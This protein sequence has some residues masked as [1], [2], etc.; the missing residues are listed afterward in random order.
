MSKEI[1]EVRHSKKNM[2]SYG[3]GNFMNEFLAMA[4]G[5]W[6]FYFYE[7]ELGLNVVLV[8]LGFFIFAVYN[9]INDP[10]VGYLTNRPFKFTKKWGRRFPWILMGAVPFIFSYI[11]IFTP[12]AVNTESGAWILFL[13]LVFTTCIFDTFNSIFWVNFS[14]LFP[15]KFRSIKERR[16]A[17]GLQIPVGLVGIALGAI[18]PPIFVDFGVPS[19]YITQ[20]GVVIIVG[21]IAI[22]LAIPGV[23]DDQDA[24]DRYLETYDSREKSP[25]FFK[26]LGAALKQKSFI[27]FI[28]SYTLYRTLVQSMTSSVPYLVDNVLEMTEKATIPIF[29]G[30]LVG[31]LISTPFWVMAAHKTNNNKK[32]MVYCGLLMGIFT[33][34]LIFLEE[35]VMLIIAMV[36]WGLSIGGYWAMIAPVLADVV[37]ESIVVLKRRQ[38]GVYAGFQQ[39]FGRLAIFF[40]ALSFT[41]AHVFTNFAADPYSDAAKFGIHIHLAVV[42]MICILIGTFVFWKWYDLT[43]EKVAENQRIIK[44]LNL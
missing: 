18:L 28:V 21:L 19:T 3:F 25:P 34:P 37:D 39:F 40:Q 23:R 16:T 42:P 5:T 27:A 32:I 6:A 2:A 4:F 36:I 8:G 1:G 22:G 43:P 13:W 17:T 12:P 31:A 44:E 38:E 20:A 11:L 29:A 10:L 24:V 14:A 30:F 9:A 41:L 15:D 35:F 7:I 33:I 26:S